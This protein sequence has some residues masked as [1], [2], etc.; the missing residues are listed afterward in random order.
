[1][2]LDLL[3]LLLQYPGLKVTMALRVPK[4]T[5]AFKVLVV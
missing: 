3:G 4:E 2:L 5:K 1:V